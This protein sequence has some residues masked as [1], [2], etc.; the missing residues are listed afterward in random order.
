MLSAIEETRRVLGEKTSDIAALPDHLV[1]WRDLP[2]C[3]VDGFELRDTGLFDRAMDRPLTD[4]EVRMMLNEMCR[5]EGRALDEIESRFG[6]S[7]AIAYM[8][9]RNADFAP[10]ALFIMAMIMG[11]FKATRAYDSA[12][13]QQSL[14]VTK[15]YRHR[16]TPQ[17]LERLCMQRRVLFNFTNPRVLVLS[18]GAF[19]LFA[20]SAFLV[21]HR[22]MEAPLDSST[23]E[24]VAYFRHAEDCLKW[25]MVMYGSHPVYKQ[26]AVDKPRKLVFSGELPKRRLG[27]LKESDSFEADER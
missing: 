21:P 7:T 12:S 5:I 4:N 18:A 2:A 13:P 17:R 15:Y 1:N 9:R 16:M 20:S 8:N 10:V 22:H 23:R 19:L 27:L 14:L 24:S 26:S 11:P 6:T 3:P 25:L